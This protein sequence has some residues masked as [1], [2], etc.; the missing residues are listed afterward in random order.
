[1]K[2]ALAGW[3]LLICLVAG[4]KKESP[5]ASYTSPEGRYTIL[6]PEQPKLK[7]QQATGAD[8]STFQQYLAMASD[9][10]GAFYAA[11]YF[12]IGSSNF[13]FDKARDGAVR[14]G[15]L[16]A[17]RDIT[18]D[19]YPGR[20]VKFLTKDPNGNEGFVVA[21]FYHVDQRVYIIQYI[22]PKSAGQDLPDKA[23]KYF[24]S[25]QVTGH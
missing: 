23:V 15:T 19:S 14:G 17:E 10:S 25:F 24:D 1:M 2:R 22:V 7:S 6:L 13:S 8:G 3:L 5:W 9:S 21:R 18:L 12:D 11:G 16:I 20:E 4:C